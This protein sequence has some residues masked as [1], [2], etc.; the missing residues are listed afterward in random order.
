MEDSNE[1]VRDPRIVKATEPCTTEPKNWS[2]LKME[3]EGTIEKI[4]TLDSIL[5]EGTS[6]E[7]KL[8]HAISESARVYTRRQEI[9][10]IVDAYTPCPEKHHILILLRKIRS[11]DEESFIGKAMVA[12]EDTNFKSGFLKQLRDMKELDLK[13]REVDAQNFMRALQLTYLEMAFKKP[14]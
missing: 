5:L 4:K 1:H 11:L 3:C 2:F 8:L 13:K 10:A 14:G 9:S 6:E 7:Q 12:F